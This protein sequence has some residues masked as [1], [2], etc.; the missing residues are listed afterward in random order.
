[1]KIM[2]KTAIATSLLMSGIA[3][4][5]VATAD[6]KLTVYGKVNATLQSNDTTERETD[7]KSNASRIGVKGGIAVNDSLKAIYKVEWQVDVADDEAD[8]FKARNQWVGLK[9]NFGSVVI[10]RNDTML[11]VAQG[12]IDL[13]NDL[14]GDIKN[15]FNGENRLDDTVT[16]VSPSFSG[17]S[18]GATFIAEDNKKSG[19]KN[20]S[21]IALMFGDKKLKKSN[22]YAAVA[23]DSDVAGRDTTRVAVQGKIDDL[24]L[25][26]IWNDSEKADGSG[27][28]DAFLVSAAYKL[29]ATTLKAQYADGDD[30]IAADSVSVG[31]DYKLAK[32]VKIFGFYTDYSF[33]DNSDKSHLALGMEYKF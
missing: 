22:I 19:G 14:S 6:E 32:N 2:Q 7:V 8:L 18:F 5:G 15:V 13:F 33:D 11:K 21:S 28:G 12:K 20:G 16:Y 27:E 9:G 29:G 3:F 24:K 10:G 26:A 4:C 30:K 25:G 31:A 23:L 17:F 1:M